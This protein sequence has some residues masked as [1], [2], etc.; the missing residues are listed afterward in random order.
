MRWLLLSAT[1]TAEASGSTE[2]P[3]GRLNRE[4]APLPSTQPARPVPLTVVTL[5]PMAL[6]SRLPPQSVK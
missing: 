1:Y 3:C 6:R 4:L 5:G 2:I